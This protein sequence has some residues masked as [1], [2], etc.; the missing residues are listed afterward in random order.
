MRSRPS[1]ECPPRPRRDTTTYSDTATSKLDCKCNP[2]LADVRLMLPA[3]YYALD[4]AVT[5]CVAQDSLCGSITS[6]DP[7]KN[8][9]T[10]S[11][12][13]LSAINPGF[14]RHSRNFS[15]S[16]P[17]FTLQADATGSAVLDPLTKQQM[18]II[19]DA[20]VSEGQGASPI[21]GLF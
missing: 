1:R 7:D 10:F 15:V 6:S 13:V 5:P 2:K 11:A 14:W 17:S 20:T 4:D 12:G 3:T 9:V 8:C 18:R 19:G 16:V 21:S